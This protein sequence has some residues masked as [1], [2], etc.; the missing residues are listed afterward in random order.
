MRDH[1]V[2]KTMIEASVHIKDGD[3]ERTSLNTI[4]R[5]YGVEDDRCEHFSLYKEH[6]KCYIGIICS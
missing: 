1:Q 2:D 4:V 3:D 6:Y 5:E